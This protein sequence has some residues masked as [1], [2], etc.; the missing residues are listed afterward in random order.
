MDRMIVVGLPL[1]P[2]SLSLGVSPVAAG[3]ASR[4]APGA[5][6]AEP[7]GLGHA[8]GGRMSLRS[9]ERET[10]GGDKRMTQVLGIGGI[11]FKA[12]DPAALRAWYR[13][14]LALDVQE[15]GGVVFSGSDGPA[16]QD[17]MTVWNIFP[18]DSTCFAPSAAPFM[19]NYRVADLHVALAELRAAGCAVDERTDESEFGRFGWV[20]DPEGNRVELWQPPPA[21]LPG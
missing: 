12:R 8:H 17:A 14:H 4:P 16:G 13:T 7:V 19:I 5:H 3:Q 21:P 2:I 1:Y 11:F 6:R 18:A 10:K 20:Q 15:W 9:W